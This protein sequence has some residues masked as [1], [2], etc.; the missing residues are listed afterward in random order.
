MDAVIERGRGDPCM[1]DVIMSGF[2]QFGFFSRAFRLTAALGVAWYYN[3]SVAAC[4]D[5]IIDEVWKRYFDAPNLGVCHTRCPEWR[6]EDSA[7]HLGNEL[8]RRQLDQDRDSFLDWKKFIYDRMFALKPSI[9]ESIRN[10]LGAM[11]LHGNHIG[12]HI[13]HGDKGIEAKPLP[14]DAYASAVVDAQQPHNATDSV[15]VASDDERAGD[16]MNALL[17]RNG[18]TIKVYSQ[19]DQSSRSRRYTDDAFLGLLTDFEALRTSKLLIGT[20]SSNFGRYAFFA[21]GP[22]G[23][24]SRS[25]DGEWGEFWAL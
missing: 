16:E 5:E 25:L 24:P 13:R 19:F 15:Y 17:R 6:T 22:R 11:G 14:F 20:Q 8:A 4:S 12:V 10:Q 9:A 7:W 2:R 23:G 3:K 1:A 18:S 21:R